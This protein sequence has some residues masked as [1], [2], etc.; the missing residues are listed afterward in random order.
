MNR[1]SVLYFLILIVLVSPSSL[2]G[3]NSPHG[4]LAIECSSCHVT[5]SWTELKVPMEFSHSATSFPLS[6][7]HATTSCK[8]CHASLKF[9]GTPSDCFSCHKDDFQKMTMPDHQ[10]G[11]FAH[12]CTTC[13]SMNGWRPSIFDHQKTNFQLT[14]SHLAVDCTSCH[15]NARFRGTPSDCFSCHRSDFSAARAPDHQRSQFSHDCV[16]C[17]TV[18]GWSASTFD[19]AKTMFPLQGAHRTVDC[20][21]CH[22]NSRFVGTPMDCYAC[23][24][25]DFTAAKAPDHAAN[26]FAHDCTTCHTSLGW[27]PSTF[28][29]SKTT[30]QLLGAHRTVDCVSCHPGG[31]FAGTQ[32]TCFAC[33]QSDYNNAASHVASQY[34]HDC[35][36]CH[37]MDAW[38][39]ASFDHSKTTFPLQGAH[40]SIPCSACHKSGQYQVLATDCFSCHQ[41]DF[42]SA[43]SPDHQAA[44]FSHDCTSCHTVVGWKPSTFNHSTTSFPLTGAHLTADCVS[45]HKNGQFKGLSTNCFSCHQTDFTNAKSPD[46]QASQFS[47]DC[48]SCHTVVGWRPST[49]NHSTTSFP[50][51]GA[52]LTADCISC[53]KNG[54]FK[55]LSTD[56]F[57]CHQTDFTGAKS[58]DHQAAQFSHDCTSCHSV[59][60][61]KPS[62]F[63]HSTTSFPLTGAHLTTDCLFC[64]KNGQFKGLSTDCF[65]CHQTDFA[66]VTDPNHVSGGFDHGCATCHTTIAWKPASFDHAKTNFPLT[67]AHSQAT[68][69]SCH[70][71][72]RFAGTP[73]DCYTCHQKDYTAATNPNHVSAKYPVTCNSCHTT[74]VWQPATFDHTPYFPINAGSHHSPGRWTFC[75]DCHTNQS[76]PATY[77]CIYCHE[78][79]QTETDSEH[80]N[81]AGYVYQSTACYKCH[82]Q[83]R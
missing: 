9:A 31:K 42:S 43:K 59:V 76:N 30:F 40:M 39:L 45:C 57:S 64:H 3:Q 16:T 63:N 73:T 77:E 68:C 21:S 82:P 71:N 1:S 8:Q 52:H 61:W 11:Q 49:F 2:R 18:N 38:S 22:P 78:H 34:A 70:L 62:T 20:S 66:G 53:H 69:A 80:R 60:L 50:L 13:H 65:S 19:H 83:G 28:D 10:R 25:T 51:T 47:H 14:G 46:H 41:T 6:G 72:N 67:G 81:R 36:T 32:S 12:D 74:A 5:T 7:L 27:R 4:V 35:L 44:Q 24:Q 29:H 17:H 23:H 37:T 56:C 55:G 79:S 75:S 54:Q 58:P 48:T 26:A 15:Q 33:H